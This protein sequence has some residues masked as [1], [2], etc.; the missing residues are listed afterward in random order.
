MDSG[1][2]LHDGG[3]NVLLKINDKVICTS[4]AQYAKGGKEAGFYDALNGMNVCTDV[5][6]VKKGD[7]IAVVAQYDLVKH[8]AR[9][10][11][12]GGEAEE[13]GLALFSFATDSAA[14]QTSQT[15]GADW[16]SQVLGGAALGLTTITTVPVVAA[17]AAGAAGASIPFLMFAPAV[18]TMFGI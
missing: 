15:A 13:M 2:H 8:P 14:V 17:L 1:G 7:K 16:M 12:S 10:H 3:T 4:K 5:N 11:A 9:A 6:P 18:K